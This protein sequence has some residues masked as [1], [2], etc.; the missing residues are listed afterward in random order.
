VNAV[1][2]IATGLTGVLI[3]ERTSWEDER[4]FL[5]ETFDAAR[6][7]AAGIAGPFVLD[8]HTRS[9]RGTLRG[10]HF[11]APHPQGKLVEVVR[12]EVFDVAVDVRRSSPN[13]GR[14]VSVTLSELNHR[15]LWVP[16]GFAHGF[17]VVSDFA[18]V[19]YKLD[20]PFVAASAR[21]VAWNDR[22]LAIPWPI[23]APLLSAKD[24]DAPSLAE[25]RDL[26]SR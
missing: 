17:C 9:K 11:Q 25:Q 15:Q 10:L 5:V 2:T 4:G 22:A 13:F 26:P 20:A 8:L 16:P 18:D 21:H 12:G 24:R 7:A 19:L 3:V 1:A 23:V 14:W 6:Y